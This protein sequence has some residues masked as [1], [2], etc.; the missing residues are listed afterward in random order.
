MRAC[1]WPPDKPNLW[2]GNGTSIILSLHTQRASCCF[3]VICIIHP[4]YPWCSTHNFLSLIYSFDRSI[5][6][7]DPWLLSSLNLRN[8]LF[9][10][11]TFHNLLKCGALKEICLDHYNLHIYLLKRSIFSFVYLRRLNFFTVTG[12]IFLT[13]FFML[14]Y[15]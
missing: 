9:Y 3:N 6:W 13:I 10:I 12:V 15:F 11:Y 8:L 7:R 4:S 14:R 5:T 2:P 1:A